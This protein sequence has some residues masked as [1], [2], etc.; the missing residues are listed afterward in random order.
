MS[1]HRCKEEMGEHCASFP[2]EE[3]GSI[4][5]AHQR[6][7]IL[8]KIKQAVLKLHNTKIFFE[9]VRPLARTAVL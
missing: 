2:I 1:L 9:Q 7:C 6:L 8:L 3:S 5:H 4:Y